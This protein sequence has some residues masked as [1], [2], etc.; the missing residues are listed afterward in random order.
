M[1][2]FFALVLSAGFLVVAPRI[3]TAQAGRG[4]DSAAV[5]A[6][7]KRLFDGMRAADSAAVRAEFAPGARFA[8][9]A[10]TGAPVTY[11]SVDGWLRGI[12]T[13]NRR[14]NEQVYDMKVLVDSPIAVAWTPY[15][16]YLDGAVRHCGTNMI[17]YLRTEAGWRI[18]QLSDSQRREN[19][20]DPLKG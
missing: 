10:R 4:A 15:T 7:I 1:K 6:S 19:C 9:P 11:D 2:K 20:P 18:T 13:S 14:W 12:A 5:L 8:A 3:A 17:V 16:F